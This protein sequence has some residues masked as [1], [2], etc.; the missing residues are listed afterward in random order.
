[1]I[2]TDFPRFLRPAI[3]GCAVAFTSACAQSI[4]PEDP[5]AAA[6]RPIELGNLLE[7]S[8]TDS[9]E[10]CLAIVRDQAVTALEK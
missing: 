6:D 5:C 7:N 2:K 4:V 3:L 10:A 1:M 8:L 9:Y